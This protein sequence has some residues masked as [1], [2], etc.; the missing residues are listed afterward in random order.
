MTKKKHQSGDVLTFKR[1]ELKKIMSELFDEVLNEKFTNIL[2]SNFNTYKDEIIEDLTKKVSSGID[3]ASGSVIPVINV[4][5]D[6]KLKQADDRIASL[7][8]SLKEARQLLNDLE[9]HSR[10]WSIRIHGLSPPVPN[11]F[12]EDAK[13]ICVRFLNDHLQLNVSLN[14]VDCAHRVGSIRNGSQPMLVKFF[15]RDFVESII[16]KRKQLKGTSYVIYEDSTLAN[17]QLLN[18]LHNHPL[19][20]RSWLSR[21]S[22]WA[23]TEPNNKFKVR[24]FDDINDLIRKATNG[25]TA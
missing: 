10:R 13:A 8:S 15:R 5:D 2:Q 18:R 4:I 25:S 9:Q 23:V 3:P 24:I 16:S 19:V 11:S 22:V 20:T 6:S 12:S 1:S 7:E 21:G 14:D 17:R